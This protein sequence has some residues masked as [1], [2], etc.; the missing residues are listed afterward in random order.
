MIASG[1]QLAFLQRQHCGEGQGYH[2]NGPATA[3]EFV[4][5]LKTK[6]ELIRSYQP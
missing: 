4:M 5:L 3:K 6:K 1:E 2:F